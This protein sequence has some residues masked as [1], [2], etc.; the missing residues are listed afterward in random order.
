MNIELIKKLVAEADQKGSAKYRVY[1]LH[2]IENGYDL[3]MNKK[4]MAKFV[5][6]GYEQGHLALNQ[7]KTDYQVKTVSALQ[8]FLTGQY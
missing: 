2:K 5:V 1:V 4:E 7:A 3:L 6:T 8:N